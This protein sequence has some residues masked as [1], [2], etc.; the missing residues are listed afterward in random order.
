MKAIDRIKRYGIK[1]YIKSCLRKEPTPELIERYRKKYGENL[2]VEKPEKYQ[3]TM[4]DVMKEDE[5]TG[6]QVEL[7]GI[8]SKLHKQP[9]KERD[10]YEV[11]RKAQGQLG[12]S[13]WR[14]IDATYRGKKYYWI[15]GE[16]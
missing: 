2:P 5:E 11:E 3:T 9:D 6:E 8:S 4:W 12:G 10:L 1:A 13:N 16:E 7:K 15:K 14:L